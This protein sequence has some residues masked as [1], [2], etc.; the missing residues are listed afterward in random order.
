MEFHYTCWETKGI[1]NQLDHDPIQ[2]RQPT[3]DSQA[4]L[5][6]KTQE[7]PLDCQECFWHSQEKI[8]GT[9]SQK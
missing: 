2:R 6:Q 8:Q 3:H 7:E 9:S 5:Q 4:A 1:H